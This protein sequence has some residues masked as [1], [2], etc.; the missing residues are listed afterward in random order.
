MHIVPGPLT[1][2][3]PSD[4]MGKRNKKHRFCITCSSSILIDWENSDVVGQ[5]P[6]LAMNA[7]L[8][9]GVDLAKAKFDFYNGWEDIEPAYG[10]DVARRA[11]KGDEGV[12]GEL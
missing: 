5:R 9:E 3:L 10:R 1:P 8:F 6:F 12:K 4:R 7:R 2:G 11:G